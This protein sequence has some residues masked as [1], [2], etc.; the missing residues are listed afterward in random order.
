LQ[1]VGLGGVEPVWDETGFW[2]RLAQDYAERL[3]GPA[4]D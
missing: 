4:R 2:D 3:I 1:R